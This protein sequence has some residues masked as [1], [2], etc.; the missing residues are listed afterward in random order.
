MTTSEEAFTTEVTEHRWLSKKAF[1][2]KLHRPAAFSFVPGQR[3]SLRHAGVERDY[4]LVSSPHES[5]LALCIR[6]VEVGQLSPAL[7]LA[8][9]GTRLSFD[10]PHG[11]FTFKPSARPAVLIATG[12]GI[13]PFRSMVRSGVAPDFILH[14]VETSAELYYEKDL[15][16]A[17]D[18]YIPCLSQPDSSLEHFEGRVTAYLQ[19][20]LA[21]DSYDFYLSGRHEM[22][23]DVT[24]LVDNLFAGSFIY[25]E[26]F[27]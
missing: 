18:K 10:G 2:I 9:T 7:C 27:Y 12:T 16:P 26:Q 14:G 21:P 3:I 5:H 8:R 19:A 25:S 15:Q 22:I 23:R 6:H 1:E 24:H 11:Y 20:H 13:A 17:A 4:S